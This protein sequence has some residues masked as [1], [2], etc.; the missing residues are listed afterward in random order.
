MFT[1][2]RQMRKS[3][4]VFTGFILISSLLAASCVT[5]QVPVVETY[6]ETEY[7]TE[8]RTE[9]YTETVNT[10]ISSKQGTSYLNIN[11]KWYTDLL[12]PG[13][14]GS[15]GTYYYDYLIESSHSKNQV[16]IDISE[17]AQEQSGMVRVY[18]LSLSGPIPPRP[19]PFQT[20]WL[21]NPILPPSE[22]SWLENLNATL[23]SSRLL[24][25]VQLGSGG[26]NQILFDANGVR[27][28]GI[29][30]TTWDAYA[31]RNVKLNWTDEVTGP[32]TV[33]GERQVPYQVPYQ[34]EKQRTVYQTE[35]VPFWDAIFGR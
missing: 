29:F 13:F 19:V 24:G 2:R 5:R 9:T 22:I 11:I 30:A 20:Y 17:V 21:N 34:V 7:K 12:I 25:E 16:E 4:L 8:Y 15:G 28:F 14:S 18:D 3:G 31:I 6:S 27:E 35:T 26:G 33:T 1:R 23:N 32:K 10:V